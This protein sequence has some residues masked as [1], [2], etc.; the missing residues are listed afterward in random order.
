MLSASRT[1]DSGSPSRQKRREGVA[2]VSECHQPAT[3]MVLK[4]GVGFDRTEFSA[5]RPIGQQPLKDEQANET[6]IQ[7]T[8]K[9]VASAVTN[10][11]EFGL[12]FPAFEKQLNLP[13]NAIDETH[14]FGTE[15][16]G[17]LERIPYDSIAL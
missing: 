6:G 4:A 9:A 16:S 8:Q 14:V 2:L 13:A 17:G 12:G 1:V 3:D 5:E 11:I 7:L 15:P 10:P